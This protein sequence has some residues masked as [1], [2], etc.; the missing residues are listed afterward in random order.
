MRIDEISNDNKFNMVMH[1][2]PCEFE[3][4]FNLIES[5]YD[6]GM[7]NKNTY[8]LYNLLD[9]KIPKLL[10]DI[11]KFIANIDK[12]TPDDVTDIY[13]DQVADYRQRLINMSMT[14]RSLK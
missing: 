6:F 12:M 10:F 13:V 8:A 4:E 14:I 7:F 9:T 11:R 3:N 5:Y 1:D 2:I